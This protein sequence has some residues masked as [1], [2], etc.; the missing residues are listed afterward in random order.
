[1]QM[2]IFFQFGLLRAAATYKNNSSK[3]NITPY[4]YE[5]IC[6]FIEY[7]PNYGYQTHRWLDEPQLNTGLKAMIVIRVVTHCNGLLLRLPF[8]LGYKQLGIE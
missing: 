7:L 4:F 5:M 2:N 1:M 3:Q 6:E 8:G